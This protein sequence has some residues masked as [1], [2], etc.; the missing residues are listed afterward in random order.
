MEVFVRLASASSDQTSRNHS[1]IS[2]VA[3]ED[4]K[5]AAKAVEIELDSFVAR[6]VLGIKTRACGIDDIDTGDRTW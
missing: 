6:H 3:D 1:A 2:C 5:P 4:Q